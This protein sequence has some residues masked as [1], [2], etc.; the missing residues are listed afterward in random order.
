MNSNQ[1]K[2]D[3]NVLIPQVKNEWVAEQHRAATENAHRL[4]TSFLMRFYIG[5]YLDETADC[6]NKVLDADI[7]R[8]T[9]TKPIIK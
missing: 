1:Q 5:Q 3:I 9:T 2:T 8:L 6:F 7:K 4:L